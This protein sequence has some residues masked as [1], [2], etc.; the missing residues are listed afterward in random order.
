LQLKAEKIGRKIMGG[1]ITAGQA[2]PRLQARNIH[3]VVVSIPP[4]GSLTHLQFRRFAGCPICNL[5]LQSFAARH[6][7]ILEAGIR[8]VVV[9]HSSDAELLPY[10]GRFPFDVIG[11]PTKV[12][13]W[14][15]GV[16]SSVSAF[17]SLKAWAAALKGILTKDKP[18]MQWTPDGG[19]M[20][21]PADF[22]IASDGSVRAVHYGTHAYDQWTVDDVL[23]LSRSFK[24][25]S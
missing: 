8:E 19:V 23:G 7:E 11:D 21:L 14:R 10:Q 6:Q 15:Y 9:F 3:G 17:L 20:G 25:G 18:K 16:E 1:K 2:F 12:L 4:S 5:H 22:L 24:V 13:Y